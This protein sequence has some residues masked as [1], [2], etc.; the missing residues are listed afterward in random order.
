MYR[1]DVEVLEAIRNYVFRGAHMQRPEL[2]LALAREFDMDPDEVVMWL[3]KL[4]HEQGFTVGA[5]GEAGNQRTEKPAGTTKRS[6]TRSRSA[7]P[8]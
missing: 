3:L 8:T 2:E 1:S 5:P 4:E 6:R 7:R